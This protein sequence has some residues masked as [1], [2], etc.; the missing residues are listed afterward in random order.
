M[1]NY[2]CK[3]ILSMLP[4]R[5]P[6]LLIDKVKDCDPGKSAVGI[7][8]VTIDEPFFAGHFPTEPIVPGVLIVE[9]IAQTTA[10]MYCSAFVEEMKKEEGK[11]QDPRE[12]AEKI[13][14][15]VGYL[16]EI[17]AMKFLKTVHPGDTMRIE[18]KKK[19]CFGIL[20]M[21]EA[22]VWVDK[23][24]VAEGKI[25]VSEKPSSEKETKTD[26]GKQI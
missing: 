3:E 11:L 20:S 25:A 17:K 6:F 4:H 5:A 10:V 16:A 19:G 12:L 1:L 8:N 21:I 7:K 26:G 22:K 23:V 18:T 24:L 14:E 15:H 13:Q 9:S 2:E